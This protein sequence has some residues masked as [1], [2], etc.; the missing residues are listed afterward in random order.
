MADDQIVIE[1][2]VKAAEMDSD[3]YD[4]MDVIG[5]AITMFESQKKWCP[6]AEMR[7][8]QANSRKSPIETD[9][10]FIGLR[11]YQ[12]GDYKRADSGFQAYTVLAPDTVYGHYYRAKANFALDTSMTVEPYVSTMVQEYKNTLDLAANNKEK[13]KNQAI[14]SSKLLAGYYN[15]IKG[16]RDSAILY[17][18]KGL[19]FDPEN[20]SIKDLIDYLQK[21][22][23]SS[24]STKGKSTGSIQPKS[25]VVQPVAFKKEKEIMVKGLV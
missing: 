9:P 4:K 7:I 23:K 8:V 2:Y 18:Q 5:K 25:A 16:D 12:C 19:D 13:F 24:K 11:F 22:N 1:S 3:Y 6:A 15:N 17:L 14:E 10:F 21:T 20:A